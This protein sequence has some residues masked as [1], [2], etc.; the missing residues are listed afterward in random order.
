MISFVFFLRQNM[1]RKTKRTMDDKTIPSEIDRHLMDFVNEIMKTKTEKL[2]AQE[3]M[4]EDLTVRS[5]SEEEA[6]NGDDSDSSLTPTD[7]A[8]DYEHI[9]LKDIEVKYNKFMKCFVRV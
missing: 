4:G 9:S 1:L 6:D 3:C 8:M 5:L 7:V 2:M